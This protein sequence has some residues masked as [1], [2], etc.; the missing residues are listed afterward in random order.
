MIEARG[1]VLADS[2]VRE[3]QPRAGRF[4]EL[5][6]RAATLHALA[7]GDGSGARFL[8][9]KQQQ[10][11][12]AGLELHSTLLGTGLTSAEI[13]AQLHA[14]NADDAVDGIFLQFPLPP[15]VDARRA[16]DIIDAVKDVDASGCGNLGRVLAGTQL[17]LPATTAAVL[18]LVE[19]ELGNLR[20]RSMVLVG[21][22]GVTEKCI[23]LV[24]VARGG[25]VCMLSPGDATLPD[26]AAGADAVIITDELPPG[27]SLR[28]VRNGALLLDAAYAAS[29]R[30]AGWLPARALD[31]LGTYLP[32]YRN[33]GP[34]TVALLMQAT[35]RAAF[36]LRD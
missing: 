3:L 27:D 36:L 7:A 6:G 35:L 14:L 15:T 16:A 1:R 2:I 4:R 34:L 26:A 29:P 19:D 17:Y 21:G 25:T 30:P 24:A 13:L 8:E 22:P 9:I 18:R 28:H 11:R 31:R 10:F 23:A 5:A 33:V 32:Q 12:A 20:G